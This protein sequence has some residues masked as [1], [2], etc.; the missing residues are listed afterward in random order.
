[1]SQLE[2]I[3][4]RAADRIATGLVGGV[5]E[6]FE[7]QYLLNLIDTKLCKKCKTKVESDD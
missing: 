4:Q 1:M 7:I 3:R 5:R 2:R 6:W